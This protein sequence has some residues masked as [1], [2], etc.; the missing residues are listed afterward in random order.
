MVGTLKKNTHSHSIEI[1]LK[2]ALHCLQLATDSLQTTYCWVKM[3][4]EKKTDVFYLNLNDLYSAIS[5]PRVDAPST[6][7]L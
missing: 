1:K 6:W 5:K 3:A 4:P 7:G 2:I